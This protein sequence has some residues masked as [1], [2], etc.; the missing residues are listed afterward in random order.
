MMAITSATADPDNV[1]RTLAELRA[2]PGQ[3]LIG[4]EWI[5]AV[6]GETFDVFNPAD[7]SRI[8]RAAAGGGQDVAR[9]VAAARAAFDA[10]PWSRMPP[11]ERGK[12]LW[13][14]ADALEAACDEFGLLETLDNG[15]PLSSSVNGDV[16]GA[17]AR[18]RYYA[19][20][21]DKIAG[22]TLAMSGHDPRGFHAFTVREPIG[23]AG[24]IVPWNAPLL[25]AANKMAPALAAGCTIILKPAEQTP[26]SALRLGQLVQE[27]GFPDGV[28]NIV[29]GMS[30]AGAALVEHPDVDKISFTGST[31]V[32]RWIVRAAAGDFKRVTLELGG[33]SPVV[34]FPDADVQQAIDGAARGIFANT[35]QICAAGSRLFAHERVFDELIEGLTGVA[36]NLKVG[37]GLDPATDL[38]PVISREQLDRVTNYVAAG[39]EAGAKA[40][41][42]GARLE[43]DG[44]FVQ[45]TILTG[46][47]RTMSVRCEEIFGPVLCAVPFSDADLDRIAGEAN[48]SVYGLAAYIYTRDLSTA[49]QMARKIKAGSIRINGGMI[50]PNVPFGGFKQSGW[51]RECGADGVESFTELKSVTIAL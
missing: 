29:T 21:A 9:A 37:P 44:Y 48:D 28:V 7:G 18:F 17:V 47:T 24:L 38:G 20:W 31:E 27:V 19:G 40:V 11:A 34:V 14:L 1:E 16:A 33:K 45:P 42:G 23:V 35:G 6:S 36:R 12:L 43:G 25:M 41:T 22:C 15:K 51:G 30:D 8:A 46:T 4:G 10:E 49:H 50:D 2:A 32:G 26:L 5:D 13:R 39:L 3:L